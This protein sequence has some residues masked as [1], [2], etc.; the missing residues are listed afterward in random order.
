MDDLVCD[1]LNDLLPCRV[2]RG[3]L[4]RE[5]RTLRWVEAGRGAPAVVLE[6]ALGEPGSLAYAG[7]M[8]A[9]ACQTRSVAYDRAGIGASDPAAPLTLHSQISDL[10]AVA[11]AV[12]GGE[13]CVLAGHSWGGL[14]T[15]LAAVQ[16]PELIAGLVLIDPA[17][18]IYW[19]QLPAEIHRES[20]ETG[21]MLIARHAAGELGPTV[22]EAFGPYVGR[23][24]ED[25]RRRDRLLDAY[26]SCYRRAW[27]A[28]MVQDETRLFD[29]SIQLIHQ[30]RSSAPLPDV[31]VVVLSATTGAA[32]EHR[33]R[34]T[35][36][37]AELARAVPGGTHI[38]LA[39]THH[40]INQD[41]PEAIAAAVGQVVAAARRGARR[42]GLAV[43]LSRHRDALPGCPVADPAGKLQPER[44]GVVVLQ[45]HL[46]GQGGSRLQGA[47]LAEE[48]AARQRGLA[49][50]RARA[51]V[52]GIAEEVGALR[53]DVHP[54]DRHGQ[55]GQRLVGGEHH[56]EAT[57][58]TG[59][60]PPHLAHEPRP[61]LVPAPGPLD[62]VQAPGGDGRQAREHRADDGHHDRDD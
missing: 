1:A 51:G 47:P 15:L 30:I 3:E 38:V 33:A 37:H 24:T 4:S 61:A 57:V 52:D 16:H 28:R 14:L 21:E 40:A 35:A 55:R 23:L 43:D 31:P 53:P 41:R 12:G 19:S 34:W 25:R 9:T 2:R 18:E 22:R 10:A 50:H 27:Q 17:D 45:L 49:L 42:R 62:P 8:A 59:R 7:V 11:A 60:R 32:E 29:D 54:V 58:G 39:D 46:P 26:E 44:V 6:A 56:R 48:Q 5:G 13:P 20:T 36:A